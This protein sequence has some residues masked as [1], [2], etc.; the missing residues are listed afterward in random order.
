MTRK[1]QVIIK[2]IV[3]IAIV[4]TLLVVSICALSACDDNTPSEAKFV[5]A[6]GIRLLDGD[7]NPIGLYGTNL[8]GWLVQESWMCPTSASEEFAQID[9]MLALYNRFGEEKAKEL[10]NLYESNWITEQDFANIRDIGLNCVRIPFSYLNLMNVVSYDS[11]TDSWVR[12]PFDELTITPDAFEKLDWALD[13]CDKYDLYAILDLHGAVGSQSGQDHSGDISVNVGRLWGDDEIGKTCRDK[14][15]ELWVQVAT[16]YKD[17]E[18]VA[19]YD[20]INE[21]GIATID[22]NGNKSQV[23]NERTWEY[24]DELIKAIRKV[25]NNHIISVESCWESFNL[26]SLEKYGWENMLYQ[27]HHYNWSSANSSNGAF[28]S[29]KVLTIDKMSNR[30]YPVLIGE[31]NV[32]GDDTRQNGTAQTDKQALAGVIEL[33]CGKGWS[34]TTWTYK[35]ASTNSSWGLY[36]Y[37]SN[38]GSMKM[39]NYLNSSYDDIVIA[40]T[41]HNSQNYIKNLDVTDC[42]TPYLAKFYT[43]N[44]LK[45]T[46]EQY[47]ILDNIEE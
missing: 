35:V 8:G 16:R 22:G 29:M 10:L 34:F 13:M 38:K 42:I 18:C 3:T 21:P 17:R 5:K 43:G 37:D 24:F 26:P 28:Y 11:A 40:W 20:I 47:Y 33:Y 44:T 6:D 39:A 46:S 30:N 14:T 32:W 12:T 31:F 15:K 23:T 19:V 25:D 45:S 41:S 36:N 7:G 27:Y 9:I 2:R 1:S 4:A